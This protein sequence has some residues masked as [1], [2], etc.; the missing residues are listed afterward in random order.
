MWYS[1]FFSIC[2]K[3]S[4]GFLQAVYGQFPLGLSLFRPLMVDTYKKHESVM[5][6]LTSNPMKNEKRKK[7][8]KK[9]EIY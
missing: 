4:R 1:A 9:V 7:K 8:K 5:L 2:K 3:K 6:R